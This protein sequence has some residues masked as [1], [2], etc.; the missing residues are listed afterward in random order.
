MNREVALEVKGLFK[1]F[2]LPNERVSG[3][4]QAVINLLKGVKGYSRQQ[5]LKDVSFKIY[6]GDFYGI[7]GRNG[8]G[9][10]TLLKLISQIYVPDSGEI[11]VNGTLVPFIELGVGFNPELTGRENVYLNG[12]LLGFST[13]EVDEM[14]E[15]IVEF[16]ELEEF[17]EQKLKNYSSG[18]QVRLAFSIAIR[19]KSDILVLDEVLAVGDESFQRK[20]FKFFADARSSGK[21]VILVTHSM[22]Q[23]QQFCNRVLLIDKGH[24][25]VEG[26]AME[27]AQIYKELND[28]TANKNISNVE[29]RNIKLDV[30]FENTGDKLKFDVRIN[31][32][33]EIKDPVVV[34]TVYRSSG[35]TAF[36]WATNEQADGEVIDLSE[37]NRLKVELK[38]ILPDGEFKVQVAVRSRD[39]STIYA[40]F[41]EVI[42]FEIVS[43]EITNGTSWKIPAKCEFK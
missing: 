12:A 19:A 1:S 13:I 3:V 41:S 17:M 23:V 9:K 25:T 26:S 35:E 33:T 10:S 6:K 39:K 16:A 34:F 2:R 36:R 15:E 27:I 42:Q 4:K 14:Y 7:V 43:K 20:C 18:M 8:S 31:S 5:V 11:T 29:N 37:Q 40:M 38:N 21:T 22:D 24:K 28:D 30:K 32:K